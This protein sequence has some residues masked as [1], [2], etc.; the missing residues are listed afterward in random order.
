MTALQMTFL[1]TA[2]IIGVGIYLSGWQQV[3]WLLYLPIIG[4]V[5]AGLTN[6]CPVTYVYKKIGFK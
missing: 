4:L 1:T 5:I 6:F 3:H 2:L